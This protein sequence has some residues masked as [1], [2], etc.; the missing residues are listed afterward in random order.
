MLSKKQLIEIGFS[1]KEAA[2]Y[3]ALLGLGPATVAHIARKAKINRTTGYDILEILSGRGLVNVL[4]EGA[5]KKYAAEDPQKII[6]YSQDKLQQ[7]QQEFEAIKKLLPELKSVFN[8]TE[9][10]KVK[11][12][13]GKEGLKEVYEDTL[14]AKKPMILGY[15]CAEPMYQSLPDFLPD[16]L[17]KRVANKIY[18]RMIAPNTAGIRELIKTDKQDLRESRL[19]PQEKLDLAIEINIY[20]NKVVIASWEEDL[21]IIIESEKIADAQKK[22]FEL[23]WEAAGKYQ[24]RKT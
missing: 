6:A 24:N 17:K 12:Y 19:I 3:L 14:T 16:Y 11:F 21:G 5:I 7:I 13:E 18:A 1:D 10:P 8:K 15:S 20:D 22:I 9:K 4:G 2:V 23:A